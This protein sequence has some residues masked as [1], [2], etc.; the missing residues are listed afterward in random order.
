MS[1]RL[2]SF[3]SA[4]K[5][6]VQRSTTTTTT[7]TTTTNTTHICIGNEAG[8]AD[9]IVSAICM[10][11]LKSMH[12]DSSS[13]SSSSSSFSLAPA[14]V[15]VAPI[16]RRM[17]RL[18]GDVDILFRSRG[19]AFDDLVCLDDL[20]AS[21]NIVKQSRV[22]LMDHN[23]MNNKVRL[24]FQEAGSD[25]ETIVDEIYDHHIDLNKHLA[26]TGH[27]RAV[28]F[29]SEMGSPLVG[30]TC[31]LVTEYFTNVIANSHPSASSSTSAASTSNTTEST[32]TT[33][34]T[35]SIV[36]SSNSSLSSSIS[37]DVD[38]AYLLLG[39]ILLDTYNMDE[40]FKR[41]TERD[42]RAIEYL[43]S[44]CGLDHAACN[45]LF[46]S[47]R[48]AKLSLEFWMGLS[49]EE[50]LDMDYKDF[51]VP[52]LGSMFGCASLGLS[53][54][55]FTQKDNLFESIFQYYS[56]DSK[57]NVFLAMSIFKDS[58]GTFHRQLLISSNKPDLFH[59][60]SSSLLSHPSLR[61]SELSVPGFEGWG[62]RG[63]FVRC[64]AQGNLEMSR[65]QLSPIVQTVLGQFTS[66]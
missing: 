42:R 58:E 3:L 41:G 60:L 66:L 53:L 38:V 1:S 20:N 43:R 29:N 27:K 24:L 9:S 40:K 26:C 65:K 16:Y 49:A 12:S 33:T 63:L 62:E 34:S 13:S 48:D 32:A 39:V 23:S 52:A 57:R 31:T 47:L 35:T 37:L 4:S 28:A 46:I 5:A 18:R 11:F 59:H 7:T 56:S 50:A 10:G 14:V 61:L 36:S 54:P 15:P 21:D 30:S 6:A 51:D 44:V 64:F 55:Q 2:K 8:D 45:N 17:L 19:I 22:I 25:P